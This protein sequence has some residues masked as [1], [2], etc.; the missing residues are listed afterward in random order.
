MAVGVEWA[1]DMFPG[2]TICTRF[3]GTEGQGFESLKEAQGGV[4]VKK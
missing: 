2:G 1:G 4:W 3:K